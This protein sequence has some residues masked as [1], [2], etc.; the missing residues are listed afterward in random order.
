M[1]AYMRLLGWLLIVLGIAGSVYC[2]HGFWNDEAYYAATK[3]LG[4]YP[5]N[6]LYQTELKMAEPRHMLLAAGGYGLGGGG[7]VFGSMCLGIA[8]LLKRSADA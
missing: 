5:N 1:G 6:V 4:K 3:G 2:W 7:L 8:T